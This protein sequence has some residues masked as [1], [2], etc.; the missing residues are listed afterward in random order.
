MEGVTVI[1]PWG[2]WG[3]GAEKY[4]KQNDILKKP[5]DLERKLSG[6]IVTWNPNL[7]LTTPDSQP[8]SGFYWSCDFDNGSF[9]A[10]LTSH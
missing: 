4:E 6:T 10:V 2:Q 1:Q 9:R 8:C 5:G 3:G 7:A